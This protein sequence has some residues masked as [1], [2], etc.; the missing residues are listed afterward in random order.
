MT[1]PTQEDI[2]IL[3]STFDMATELA[4]Q[5]RKEADEKGVPTI[6]M[7][8]KIPEELE[9]AVRKSIAA[10]NNKKDGEQVND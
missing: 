7:E 3:T 8:F 10:E 9:Q 6:P 1:K 2:A 5:A 4:V